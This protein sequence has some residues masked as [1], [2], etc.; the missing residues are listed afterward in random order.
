MSNP[1]PLYLIGDRLPPWGDY[2]G[3][4]RDGL[5]RPAYENGELVSVALERTG[6]F[7]PPISFPLGAIIVTDDLRAELLDSGFS[8]LT[9]IPASLTK[10]VRLDWSD[11]DRDGDPPIYPAG[12]EPENYIL[13]R[14]HDAALAAEMPPLWAWKVKQTPGLQV[15]GGFNIRRHL[16]PGTD[17]AASGACVWV[18]DRVK[19]WLEHRVGDWLGFRPVQSL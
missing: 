5:A 7:V 4:L 3:I 19:A 18:S 1:D 8:G 13:R 2:G 16:H 12:G 11:W 6:P 9:C 14:K 15:L 17:V 10:V